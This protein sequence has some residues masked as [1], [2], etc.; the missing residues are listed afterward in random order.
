VSDST[1][2]RGRVVDVNGSPVPSATIVIVA[3]TVPMP[4]IAIV[5]DAQ[6]RF[7]LN[8]PPGRFTLRAHSPDGAVGE[9]DVEGA[10]TTGD[11]AII[12]GR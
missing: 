9:S 2:R 3:S 11:I 5:S 8:L 4:E 7:T 1:E 10:S 6:G 12:I